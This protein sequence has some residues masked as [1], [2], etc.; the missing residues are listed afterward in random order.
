M[1][2][3]YPEENLSFVQSFVTDSQSN[4]RPGSTREGKDR[5]WQKGSIQET[6]DSTQR[7]CLTNKGTNCLETALP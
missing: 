5:L 1:K 7:L 4:C 2:E 6:E 3:R